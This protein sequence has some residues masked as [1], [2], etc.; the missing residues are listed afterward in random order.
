MALYERSS[1]ALYER[2]SMA[3]SEPFSPN[4]FIHLR[5]LNIATKFALFVL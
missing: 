4:H 5:G 2:S 1:M 3:F